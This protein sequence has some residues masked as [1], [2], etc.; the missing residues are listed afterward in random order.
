MHKALAIAPVA[1]Q[2]VAMVVAQGATPH[3]GCCA[4]AVSSA[5][6]GRV[7][8]SSSTPSSTGWSSSRCPIREF[9]AI[10]LKRP[11]LHATSR[12]AVLW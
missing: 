7:L 8:R 2:L 1:C 9:G 3:P 10:G 5:K 4:G 12:G 6:R 11:N